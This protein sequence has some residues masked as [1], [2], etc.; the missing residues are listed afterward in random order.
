MFG[1]RR[2]SEGFEW[3]EYVRTTILVR[4]ADRQ[5][6]IDDARDAA[7]AKVKDVRDR[8]VD[9]GKAGI[10]VVRDGVKGAAHKA[11][12]GAIDILKVGADAAVGAGRAAADSLEGAIRKIP[13]ER[14]DVPTRL[15]RNGELAAM[16][17]ADLPRR[18]RKYRGHAGTA[19]AALA[20]IYVF[21]SVLTPADDAE[22]AATTAQVQPSA[23]T[24][25][26]AIAERNGATAPARETFAADTQ[27]ARDDGIKRGRASAVSGDTLRISGQ[28]IALAGIEAPDEQYPCFNGKGRRWSCASSASNALSRM[29]RGR[30]VACEL[31]DASAS[32]ASVASG[33]GELLR[34]HCRVGDKD[35]A[36]ELVRGGHV[37]ASDGDVRIYGSDEDAARTARAGI[38]QVGDIDRPKAWRARVWDDAKRSAPD[39]CPIKGL[40]KSGGRVYAM[41]WSSGYSERSVK[42]VRGERWFCTED[43]AKAAGFK[44]ASRS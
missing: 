37:F 40:V 12:A 32:S 13:L 17:V 23:V 42:A 27:S 22:R 11:G 15:K 5:R 28:S 10:D 24:T 16:Y 26:G 4:R 8:G 38:W 7:L 19:L 35:I 6:R 29:I 9:A 1:W 31:A 41:P 3:R 30:V 34:G 36:A 44:P 43:E 25:T 18:W 39:G 21:G 14:P 20:G 33:G 2:R